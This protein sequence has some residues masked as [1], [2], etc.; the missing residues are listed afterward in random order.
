M[1]RGG[2]GG[3]H[4][5]IRAGDLERDG[6]VP[7]HQIDDAAR[8]EKR[9]HLLRRIGLQI[10]VVGLFDG[11]EAAHARTHENADAIGVLLGHHQPRIAHGLHA[12]HH[13]VLHEGIHAARILRA[14]VRLEIEIANL[15]AEMGGE[16]RGVEAGHRADAAAT[17]QDGR[18][19]RRDIVAHRRNDTKTRNH[20]ASFA[21]PPLR[22]QV[23]PLCELM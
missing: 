10:L 6:Q 7:A 9:R 4:G 22:Y 5:Q 17:R 16:I 21:Q 2:A 12:G 3:G 14:H 23:L 8:N 19:S 15:A 18:P 11:L 13:A 20:D 1:S